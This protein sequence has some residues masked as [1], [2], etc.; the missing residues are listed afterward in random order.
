MCAHILAEKAKKKIVRPFVS[1]CVLLSHSKITS[2]GRI[3]S[4]YV[5]LLGSENII[6]A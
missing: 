5:V 4:H 3:Y 1:F 2:R 6:Q